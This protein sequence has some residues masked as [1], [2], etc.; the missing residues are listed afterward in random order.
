MRFEIR[1]SSTTAVAGSE[2]SVGFSAA[3]TAILPISCIGQYTVT[4][5]GSITVMLNGYSV[6][7]IGTNANAF[8]VREGNIIA[9]VLRPVS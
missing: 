7:D 8:I 5:A 2:N 3:N 4:T 6:Y 9:T 1:T